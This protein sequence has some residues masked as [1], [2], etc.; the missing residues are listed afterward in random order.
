[1]NHEG[2]QHPKTVELYKG[3]FKC[4]T[5]GDVW[6]EATEG[7]KEERT[8]SLAEGRRLQHQRAAFVRYYKRRNWRR[9]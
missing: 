3:I 6:D 7:E 9:R 5:C 4:S 8:V 1:M 2:C